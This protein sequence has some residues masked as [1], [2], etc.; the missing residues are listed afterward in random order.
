MAKEKTC[1]NCG[2]TVDKKA[3]VCTSCG[4]KIKKPIYK[5]WWFWVI[6]VIVIIA[7][8]TSNNTNNSTTNNDNTDAPVV[9]NNNT[10]APKTEKNSTKISKA[11]FEAL[12]T[13]ITYEEAVA[14]IGGEGELSSQVD[15]AGYDTKMYT[16][17]GE[18]SIGANANATFQ[19]NS[20]TSKA[21]FGLK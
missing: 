3:V 16:W 13:G 5:K 2:Q 15:V 18:G 17:K 10:E 21:Q 12:E 4:V 1:K 19:N 8:G 11:E 14:I 9:E 20:L 6:V 7:I